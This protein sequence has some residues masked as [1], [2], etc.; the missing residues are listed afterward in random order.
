[1]FGFCKLSSFRRHSSFWNFR[2]ARIFWVFFSLKKLLICCCQK[3]CNYTNWILFSFGDWKILNTESSCPDRVRRYI[4]S[5]Q[6]FPVLSRLQRISLSKTYRRRIFSRQSF[7]KALIPSFP[8]N[9]STYSAAT[10]CNA[11]R[12]VERA[13]MSGEKKWKM[14]K[15]RKTMKGGRGIWGIKKNKMRALPLSRTW[16]AREVA[17]V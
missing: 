10:R 17:R 12:V 1:M 5:I 15:N 14:K 8:S 2:I 4:I 16:V 6:R 13:A 3:T 11:N 9:S 7:I